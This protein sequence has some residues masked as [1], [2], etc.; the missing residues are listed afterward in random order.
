[1]GASRTSGQCGERSGGGGG[2]GRREGVECPASVSRKESIMAA[3][4]GDRYAI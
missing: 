3:E 4:C 1:M 2:G